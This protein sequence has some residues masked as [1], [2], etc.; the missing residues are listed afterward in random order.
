MII[1]SAPGSIKNLFQD[2]VVKIFDLL[3]SLREKRLS[4]VLYVL[5]NMI[6]TLSFSSGLITLLIPFTSCKAGTFLLIV[7]V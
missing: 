2:L 7:L 6:C 4:K 3:G 1:D 5:I